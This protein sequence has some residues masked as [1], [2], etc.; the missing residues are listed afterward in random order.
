MSVFRERH[1]ISTR[2]PYAVM[3]SG[4]AE[5]FR[6]WMSRPYSARPRVVFVRG[7]E[8]LHFTPA[9]LFAAEEGLWGDSCGG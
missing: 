3:L 4:D 9:W 7:R 6:R 1:L 8:V 5:V 2:T